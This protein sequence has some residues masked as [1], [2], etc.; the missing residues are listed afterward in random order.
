VEILQGSDHQITMVFAARLLRRRR[1]EFPF[2]WPACLTT[3]EG[4]CRGF[5]QMTLVATP[6][7]DP[8]AESELVRVDLQAHLNQLCNNGGHASCGWLAAQPGKAHHLEVRRIADEMKWSPVKI[9]QWRSPEG[10][11][12]STNW[13]LAVD[14]LSRDDDSMPREGV[15][16][17][18]LL[19]IG[20]PDGQAPVFQEMRQL[21]QANGVKLEQ[22]Q[23]AARISPRV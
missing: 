12:T 17:T 23:T 13:R 14:H 22:I 6:P 4:K 9:Y 11:G 3:K 2:I 5:A 21:L 18:A 10:Q 16:F 8:R 20:D 15:P 19:T 7:V 1:L